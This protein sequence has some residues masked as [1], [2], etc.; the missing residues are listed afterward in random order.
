MSEVIGSNNT[1]ERIADAARPTMQHVSDTVSAAAQA[2]NVKAGQLRETSDA[3]LDGARDTV[4]S[5]PLAVV[6]GA[7]ALGLL[8]SRLTRMK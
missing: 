3:W 2:V 5:N 1:I 8:I 7:L 4:R 6:A